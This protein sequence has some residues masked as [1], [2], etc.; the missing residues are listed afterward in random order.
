MVVNAKVSTRF[1][2]HQGDRI[3]GLSGKSTTTGIAGGMMMPPRRGL[4]TQELETSGIKPLRTTRWI[5]YQRPNSRIGRTY[6]GHTARGGGL[7]VGI[8]GF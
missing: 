1:W 6:S 7:S 4:T 8:S 3:W 2:E 5:D